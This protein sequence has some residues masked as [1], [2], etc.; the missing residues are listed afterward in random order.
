MGR[1]GS[2]VEAPETDTFP[3]GYE[4]RDGSV[5]V[6]YSP[7]LA[8]RA[9]EVQDYLTR[10]TGALAEILA[11]EPPDL[12]AFLVA[13]GDWSA[14]PRDS[15]RSYP[16]GLPYFTRSTRPPALVLPETLSPA[17][18]PRTEATLPLT[19]WHELTHAFLLQRGIVRTP[20]WLREFVPQAAASAVARRTGLPLEKH[21]ARIGREPG[22]T[23]RDFDGP[24]SAGDQMSFQNILLRLGAAALEEFGEDFL[25]RVSHAL[26]EEDEIVD[27][28]R[29][30]ELLA[31]ALGSG[32]RRWLEARP[33]F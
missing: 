2:A 3:A 24:A 20:A 26:R 29:A 19:V 17:F 1:D 13:D 21:L 31:G 7:R 23:V 9:Q 12:T 22:F 30:E 5:P 10:G 8:E 16:S 33:E 6:L 14:A 4:H 11:V 27:Q 28:Q 15:A 25:K 32:G 18:Q